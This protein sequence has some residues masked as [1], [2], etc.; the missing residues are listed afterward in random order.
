MKGGLAERITGGPPM[1][2]P[3]PGGP[4]S[5]CRVILSINDCA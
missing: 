4:P 3:I 2:I 1:P 5:Y